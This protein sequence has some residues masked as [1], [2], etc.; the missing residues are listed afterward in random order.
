MIAQKRLLALAQRSPMTARRLYSTASQQSQYETFDDNIFYTPVRRVDFSNGKSTIF[1]LSASPSQLR[2]VPWEVKETTVKNFLG[3]FGMVIV[4]YLFAPGAGFYTAGA[5][6]FGLNWMYRVYSYMGNAITRIDLHDDG[7]T[8]TVGF[9]TGGSATFKVKDILKKQHEKELVQTFE[10]GFLF[11]IEVQ[12]GTG[13]AAQY[14]IYGSGQDAIKNGELFRAIIN[15]Q[16][17]RV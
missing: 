6:T 14:Y 13:K 17:V 10:E 5:L 16:A 3:V 11:P 12:A 2:S 4:D 15:G 9:K 1:H 8:V 7:K